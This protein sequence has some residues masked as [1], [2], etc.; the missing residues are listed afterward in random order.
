M[1]VLK[2]VTS[3][4]GVVLIIV[5]AATYALWPRDDEPQDPDAVV[6]LGGAGRER[7]ELGIELSQRYDAQLVLSSSAAVFGESQ[8][9][10]CGVDTLC[11]DPVPETT[12]GEARAIAHLAAENGWGHVTVATSRFHT[13]R[14]RI[15]FRQCL[16]DAVT[17]VG[18][19]A[20]DRRGEFW[21]HL[22]EAVATAAT[23][24]VQRAC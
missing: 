13:T 8:G 21:R 14:A 9:A 15:A 17:V 3:V 4:L 11:I 20:P 12:V 10:E 24:T 2:I 5:A 18:A 1:L 6:V 19:V 23:L 16:G 7:A 22:R